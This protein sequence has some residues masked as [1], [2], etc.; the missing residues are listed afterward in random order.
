M[1]KEK[2]SGGGGMNMVRLSNGSEEAEAL[3][4]VTMIK[5]VERKK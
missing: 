4:A 3:V 5:P 2:E 1:G